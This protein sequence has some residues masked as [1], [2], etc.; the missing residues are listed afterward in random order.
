MKGQDG[1]SMVEYVYSTGFTHKQYVLR[2]YNADGHC[3]DS[4][5]TNEQVPMPRM[6]D[7]LPMRIIDKWC[8][9]HGIEFTEFDMGDFYYPKH[10]PKKYLLFVGGVPSA[11]KDTQGQNVFTRCNLCDGDKIVAYIH[12]ISLE[13]MRCIDLT[14]DSEMETKL[15]LEKI[16]NNG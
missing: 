7:D 12:I 1:H 13:S 2:L 5:L 10:D 3:I 16:R 11:I 6:S 4:V 9:L 14:V 15:L 8:A